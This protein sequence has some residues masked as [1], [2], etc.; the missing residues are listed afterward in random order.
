MRPSEPLGYVEVKRRI[1]IMAETGVL[2]VGGGPSGIGAVLGASKAGA[3]VM[4]AERY[5]FLGGSATAGLVNTFMSYYTSG[6]LSRRQARITLFPTDHGEG[7][8][9]IG[10]VLRSFVEAMVK[11]GGAIPPSQETGYVVP[12]DPEIFKIVSDR[13]VADAGVTT[14]LHSFAGSVTGE[15]DISGV[16]LETKG[17]PMMIKASSF[18]DCTGDGDIAAMAGAEYSLGRPEDGL[19]QPMT[20]MFR[21]VGFDKREFDAYVREHPDQWS[22]VSGLR[23]LVQKATDE[24]RLD[25]KRDDILFFGTPH[26]SELSVNSTRIGGELGISV[27]GLTAAEIEGRRQAVQVA[28]FLKKYVP[29]FKESYVVQTAVNVGVRET[30]RVLGDYVITAEDIRGSAMF[31][32][33]IA[34]ASYPMDMHSPKGK[35]TSVTRLPEGK[36]YAIPLRCLLPKGLGNILVAGRCI[37]GTHEAL[38]SYRTMATSMATGQAAGVAAALASVRGLPVRKVPVGDIQRE[39][40]RQGAD[41]GMTK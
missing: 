10:G 7:I 17:G 3:S 13:I 4:L 11:A 36:S 8:P 30:R 37:S 6:P 25:L 18:V 22:G 19:T 21:I 34:R 39:L 31:E 15:G 38:S 41:I 2:V 24:G 27:F 28:A 12:I 16:V 1:P 26:P 35:G 20:L 33:A 9:V 32:D 40:V 29:G 23:S 5:G 14:L